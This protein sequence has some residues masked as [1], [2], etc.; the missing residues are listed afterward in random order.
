ML[1]NVPEL[2]NGTD[3][4]GPKNFFFSSDQDLNKLI[5]TPRGEWLIF[6]IPRV[7]GWHVSV[8][9]CYDSFT[10]I[11]ANVT[12]TTGGLTTEPALAAWDVSTQRFGTDAI[13]RQLGVLNR[14]EQSQADRGVMSL[15]T[16]PEQ[17]RDQVQ[18]WYSDSEALGWANISFPDQNFIAKDLRSRYAFGTIMCTECGVQY[19]SSTNKI[20][21]ESIDGANEQIFQ[22]VMNDTAN[23]ALAFQA[24][25]TTIGQIAYYDILS[26]FDVQDHPIIS[27]FQSAQFPRSS[28]GLRAVIVVLCVHFV[29][30]SL[31]TVAFLTTTRVSRIGDNVW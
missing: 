9:L 20:Q 15:Q 28:R 18:V 26:Y 1:S 13:R 10:S 11:D 27:W 2:I 21:F 24:Y 6:T 16:T 19:N 31:T 25:C 8:S 23:T 12:I 4:A 30:V 17:L 14:S 5:I 7:P 3:P 22:D 29:L